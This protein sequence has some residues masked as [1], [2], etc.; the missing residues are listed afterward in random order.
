MASGKSSAKSS[1]AN[2]K[3]SLNNGPLEDRFEFIPYHSHYNPHTIITK[4]GELMQV[5]K[6]DGNL[7]GE[8]CENLD[9]IHASVCSTIRQVIA[10]NEVN[11]KISFWLHTIRKRNPMVS[12]FPDDIPASKRASDEFADY[13]N[14]HWKKEHNWEDNFK[15]EIYLT[16]LYEGQ[17][18]PLLDPKK[19]KSFAFPKANSR[20]CNKYIDSSYEYLDSLT[21][22]I[23]EGIQSQCSAKRLGL[24]ERVMPTAGKAVRQPI[25]YS[26]IMEFLGRILNLRIEAFPLPD[27]DLSV[28]LQTSL[29]TFGFNAIEVRSKEAGDR[30]FAAMLTVKQYIDM[31][32]DAV[33]CVLQAPIEMVVSQSFSYIP[34]E[35]ALSR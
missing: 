30:R 4:N 20:F 28:A 12:S 35:R 33:D 3:K 8:L 24:A 16:I 32:I 26:E 23:L 7:R 2:K 1:A 25:F 14:S 10:Q 27:L 6:I 5:I 31:P 29:L 9:G 18:I 11:E 15:N 19:I 17:A 22:S 13:V 34:A 21:L